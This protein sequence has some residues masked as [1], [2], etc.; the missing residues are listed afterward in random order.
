MEV[1]VATGWK[2]PRAKGHLRNLEEPSQDIIKIQVYQVNFCY[3][4]WGYVQTLRDI[5]TSK[6]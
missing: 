4:C 3:F 5:Y 6:I 1:E 2:E